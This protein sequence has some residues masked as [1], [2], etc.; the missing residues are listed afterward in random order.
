MEPSELKKPIV[1]R[2]L[3]AALGKNTEDRIYNN[4]KE[5]LKK[6]SIK[7]STIEKMR[8][9]GSGGK[10]AYLDDLKLRFEKEFTAEER[11]E[12]WRFL[13]DDSLINHAFKLESGKQPSKPI[14]P[15][16]KNKIVGFLNGW[17]SGIL[18]QS[19]F[20]KCVKPLEQ[21]INKEAE[22]KI[23]AEK[24]ARIQSAIDLL[25]RDQCGQ[26]VYDATDPYQKG[27]EEKL[28]GDKLYRKSKNCIQTR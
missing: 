1:K 4:F 13:D 3:K 10:L 22:A 2:I 20:E 18:R 21:Q 7:D 5:D 12:F 14:Y 8:G 6:A 24:E 27:A 9:T 25:N 16:L 11:T 17:V 26:F 19:Q 23:G 15:P 28:S